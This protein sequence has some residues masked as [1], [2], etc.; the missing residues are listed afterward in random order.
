MKVKEKKSS[1]TMEQD[2]EEL[3]PQGNPIILLLVLL[4][5]TTVLFFL[6]SALANGADRILSNGKAGQETV[7][8]WKPPV[9]NKVVFPEMVSL[10][11]A[12]DI[13]DKWGIKVD[14]LETDRCRLHD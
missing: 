7:K 8:K 3:L 2:E 6:T 12:K 10:D 9:A 14:Q 11:L 4:L 13:A 5:C 1:Y